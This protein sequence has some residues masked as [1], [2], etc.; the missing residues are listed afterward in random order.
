MYSMDRT[1][2]ALQFVLVMFVGMLTCLEIGRR[3]G[4]RHLKRDPQLM[5]SHSSVDSA[6][7]ALWTAPG[8]Y[9]FGSAQ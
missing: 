7:F 2:P 6:V 1:I 9:V 5:S 4:K 8:I 3:I